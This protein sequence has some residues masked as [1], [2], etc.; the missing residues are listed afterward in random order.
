MKTFLII[1]KHKAF[2]KHMELIIHI[3]E[4]ALVIRKNP[5]KE[6]PHLCHTYYV[7]NSIGNTKVCINNV[8]E[9]VQRCG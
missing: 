6:I 4:F 9:L 8:L 2:S 1:P 7:P 3:I 5:L